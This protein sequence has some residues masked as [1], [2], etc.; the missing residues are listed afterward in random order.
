MEQHIQNKRFSE[1]ELIQYACFD[2]STKKLDST[3]HGQTSSDSSQRPMV[4]NQSSVEF[5]NRSQ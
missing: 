5:T 1:G 2:A 4:L 3:T